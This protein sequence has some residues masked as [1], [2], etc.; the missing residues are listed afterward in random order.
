MSGHTYYSCY[1]QLLY[2]Y[3]ISLLI[4]LFF[5]QFIY[6]MGAQLKI[7]KSHFH[8]TFLC[9]SRHNLCALLWWCYWSQ[10][11][12]KRVSGLTHFL[13]PLIVFTWKEVLLFTILTVSCLI[14]VLW[15][16]S[17][18]SDGYKRPQWSRVTGELMRSNVIPAWCLQEASCHYCRFWPGLAQVIF[19]W[20]GRGNDVMLLALLASS[21]W[22]V[23]CFGVLILLWLS[24]CCGCTTSILKKLECVKCQEYKQGGVG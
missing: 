20:I 2:M 13:W 23:Y 18:C 16:C 5:F 12:S 22:W 3:C 9:Q 4:D 19:V 10:T 21:S 7:T 8:I 15:I 11:F 24:R 14:P 17:I 6:F 1:F